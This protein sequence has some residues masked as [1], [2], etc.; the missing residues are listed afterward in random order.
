MW[1]WFAKYWDIISGILTGLGLAVVSNFQLDSIQLLYSIVI[2]LLVSIGFFKIVKQAVEKQKEKKA[3]ERERN[4]IDNMV[5]GQKAVKAINIAS[6]P[7]KEGEKIGNLFINIME[8]LK[9]IMNKFTQWFDK[10]KGYLLTIALAVLPV[11][12]M[13]GG[14][15][16]QLCG[17]VM[18]ING[19]EV[20]PLVTLVAS[21]VVGII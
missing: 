11:V 13:Y 20:L 9:G 19:V 16:N 2:L 15:I 6:E 18:V 17:G 4:L 7:T 14:F 1:S 21:L 10:V 3:K 12:E 8:V 5:D